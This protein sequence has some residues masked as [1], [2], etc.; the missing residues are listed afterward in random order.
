MKP[1]LAC[2]GGAGGAGPGRQCAAARARS[3]RRGA[4]EPQ[5]R[6]LRLSQLSAAGDRGYVIWSAGWTGGT[7]R[8]RLVDG[9][10][11]FETISAW[12]T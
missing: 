10:W 4:G 1:G 8:L 5:D 6:Q 2:P 11:I 9:R 12:I 3:E 7:C